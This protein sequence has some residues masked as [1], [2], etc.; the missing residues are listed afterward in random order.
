FVQQGGTLTVAGTLSVNGSTVAGGTGGNVGSGFGAGFF[1]QGDGTITFQPGANQT[2]TISDIIADQTGSGGTGANAGAYALTKSGAG[3]LTLSGAN[4]YS[5]GTTVA[6]GTLSLQNNSA[7]GTGA[8]TTTGSVIDY[9]N[10]VVI[11]NPVVVN[12]NTTQLQVLTGTA[13]QAGVI[14]EQNGPRPLEKIG[15]G[16]LALT[17]SNT[18]N[19][20]TTISA[21][22]LQVGNGG[23]TG[24][25]GTGNVVN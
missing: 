6:G 24:T 11:A 5:G 22:T 23:T 9:A 1:G 4:T 8:I 14:S 3:T 10:G 2:Q 18:Y 17:G 7:A 15:D 25:L 12:S 16:T 21:G 19:G 13:T 20:T